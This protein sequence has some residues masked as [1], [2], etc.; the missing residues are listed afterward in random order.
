MES[1]YKISLLI[2][3]STKTSQISSLG[4]LIYVQTFLPE[5]RDPTNIFIDVLELEDVTAHSWLFFSL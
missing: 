4:V 2:V 3:E 1:E 5:I